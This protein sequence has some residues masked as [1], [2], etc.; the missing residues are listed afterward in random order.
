[1][2][3]EHEANLGATLKKLKDNGAKVNRE[4]CVFTTSELMFC[5]HVFARNKPLQVSN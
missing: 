1:M 5:R 4:E 2:A 3:A